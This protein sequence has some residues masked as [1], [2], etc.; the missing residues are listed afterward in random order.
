[1]DELGF[2]KSAVLS[3]PYPGVGTWNAAALAAKTFAPERLYA[4][5]A[6]DYRDLNEP[7]FSQRA[8]ARLDQCVAAGADGVK[9]LLGKPG[10]PIVH[11]PLTHPRMRPIYEWFAVE[12]IPVM[13]HVGDVP[14]FWDRTAVEDFSTSVEWAG[15]YADY[16]E[17]C[18][19]RAAIRGEVEKLVVE[20]SDVRFI[21]AHLAMSAD[22]LSW[23]ASVLDRSPAI[24]TDLSATC[25]IGAMARNP[26]EAREFLETYAD[27]VCF[28]TDAIFGFSENGGRSRQDY[29]SL[30][31]AFRAFLETDSETHELFARPYRGVGLSES[32]LKKIYCDN[33]TR[34]AGDP[35][36]MGDVRAL[37]SVLDE[38]IDTMNSLD[39]IQD[40]S[41]S[42]ELFVGGLA[43][44]CDAF[45][46]HGSAD[47]C[48]FNAFKIPENLKR[49]HIKAFEKMKADLCA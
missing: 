36:P 7:G 41:W 42:D 11:F 22:S 23:L 8:I 9:M 2:A 37:K 3:V 5:C 15:I 43:G 49:N 13:L 14:H 40:D 39:T 44:R 10:N 27:R 30:G 4:F 46:R 32:A 21:F 16:R 28:G 47:D 1:M 29:V 33:F 48:V 45:R 24:A 35:K 34:I 19:S 17:V 18:P 20:H 31:R 6:I 25:T 38:A 26:D 12:Q